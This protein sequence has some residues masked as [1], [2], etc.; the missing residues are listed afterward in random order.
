MSSNDSPDVC[1]I[2]AGP[3]GLAIAL[4]LA[5]NGQSVTL[6]DGGGPSLDAE[7]SELHEGRVVS[8]VHAEDRTDQTLVGGTLYPHNHLA[9]TRWRQPGGSSWRWCA[10]GRPSSDHTVRMVEA[11]PADFAPRPLFEIPGFPVPAADILRYRDDALSFLDLGGHSFDPNAYDDGHQPVALPT[12]FYPKLFHFPAAD[13]VQRVRPSEAEAH[14]A[15]DLRTGMH[16]YRFV[17]R[18]QRIAGVEFIDPSGVVKTLTP[19]RIVLTLGG[20]ENSRQLLIGAEEGSI[21]NPHDLLGRYFVDH[22]HIRLGYLHQAALQDL[23]YYDFQQIR[24]TFVLRG[25]GIDPGFADREGLLRFSIDVVGRHELDGT[26]TGYA[27]ATLK[28]GVRRRQPQVIARSLAGTLRHPLDGA[29]LGLLAKT[30]RVHH[31]GIGGWSDDEERLLP[32]GLASVESMFEQRPSWDNR[33]RLGSETDRYG[34]RQPMLQWSFSDSEVTAIR[35]AVDVTSAAFDSAGLGP[36]TT[37]QSLGDGT[38]PRAGTGMHHMG[39][40]RM[41]ADPEQG[42]VDA[43]GRMHELDNLYLAGSSVFPTSVGYANPTFTILQMALR[44][45]D[46][47]SGNPGPDLN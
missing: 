24:D 2:G 42:V 45:A 31:T 3:A 6:V 18:G 23:S 29:R 26:H 25:H 38:I 14:P 12:E 21:P 7:G 9:T 16:L 35:R 5:A 46:H 15:I 20:I 17:R 1:V 27:L 40:T 11:L 44:L 10:R 32:V 4:R 30:G 28:D 39:G 13:V 41:H 8:S 33:V 22:P 37:M 19:G 34:R 36:L 47:L 43:H